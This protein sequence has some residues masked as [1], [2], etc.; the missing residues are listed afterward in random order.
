MFTAFAGQIHN[1]K[2]FGPPALGGVVNT[3]FASF[4][5]GDTGIATGETLFTLPYTA[6]IVGYT[7]NIVTAFDGTGTN[8]IDFGTTGA[9]TTF[10]A[11]L[12]AAATGQRSNGFVASAMF[13]RQAADVPFI[14]RYNG[15]SPS[16]GLAWIAVQYVMR[17]VA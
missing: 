3:L 14:V 8:T 13:S 9:L 15:T 10:A 12:S 6:E 1:S 5:F 4:A 2:L 17:A 11:A 16:V 7:L